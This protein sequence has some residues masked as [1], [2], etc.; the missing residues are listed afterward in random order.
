MVVA[1]R[2]VK[3]RR[4]CTFS[5]I[6]TD[7]LPDSLDFGG[8]PDLFKSKPEIRLDRGSGPHRHKNK[9]TPRPLYNQRDQPGSAQA[10]VDTSCDWGLV[11]PPYRQGYGA[12]KPLVPNS[13]RRKPGKRTAAFKSLASRSNIRAACNSR[14]QRQARGIFAHHGR[15]LELWR[16]GTGCQVENAARRVDSSKQT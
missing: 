11:G 3:L 6:L 13:H 12:D 2:E 10:V 1:G 14:A 9:R 15:K 5:T 16:T 7:V 4:K 8:A